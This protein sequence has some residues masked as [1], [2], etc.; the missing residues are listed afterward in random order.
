MKDLVKKKN[1]TVMVGIKKDG[2]DR[3]RTCVSRVKSPVHSRFATYPDVSY[4]ARTCI[5]GLEIPCPFHWTNET[6][7]PS[8]LNRYSRIQSPACSNSSEADVLHT[9]RKC[10]DG[11]EPS[12]MVLQTTLTTRSCARRWTVFELNELLRI[13]SPPLPPSQLTVLFCRITPTIENRTR[14]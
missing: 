1:P 7:R 10:T 3:S 5:G 2:Y 13:F 4:R 12:R 6:Q 8:D 9:D 11:F 14:K